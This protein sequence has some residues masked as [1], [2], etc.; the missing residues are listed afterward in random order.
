MAETPNN[1][2]EK[3]LRDYAA[4]RRAAAGQ[5]EMHPATRQLLQ[6]EVK[7]QFGSTTE[8]AHPRGWRVLWPRFAMALSV[9]AVI[10]V[11]VVV[12]QKESQPAVTFDLAKNEIDRESE[13]ALAPPAPSTAPALATAPLKSDASER[14]LEA[15]GTAVNAP[16]IASRNGPAKG[17]WKAA[18]ENDAATFAAAAQV[19][20]AN[21]ELTGQAGTAQ[22]ATE[23]RGGFADKDAT[24]QSLSPA[25]TA[26]KA[27]AMPQNDLAPAND[28]ARITADMAATA[29]PNGQQASFANNNASTQRFRNVVQ[30][31]PASTPTNPA[32]LVEFVVEQE[33]SNLK[34]VD[35]DGSV[36]NGYVRAATDAEATSNLNY[37]ANNTAQFSQSSPALN[38]MLSNQLAGSLSVTNSAEA[39]TTGV[40][41]ASG[42]A[43]A[44]NWSA[45]QNFMFEVEGTN[46]SSRQRVVFNGNLIQ[47]TMPMTTQNASQAAQNFRRQDAPLTLQNAVNQQLRN[48]FINGRVYLGNSRS[49]TELNALSVDE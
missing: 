23:A 41:V 25:P 30:Q 33:G 44:Q 21:A 34:I 12:L 22:S 10:A 7:Q 45:P 18:D 38:A 36:Y 14:R 31:Q 24:A 11:A 15:A 29:A 9:L 40:M 37:V 13:A 17:G 42:G 28:A 3:Q 6:A 39:G 2:I 1:N 16:A 32:V 5:P 19:Q 43:Q 49:S 47:N 48:N 4:Q 26:G 35:R 8:P 20:T 27:G 46:R